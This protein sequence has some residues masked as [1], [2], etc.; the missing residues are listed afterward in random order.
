MVE[1]LSK[2]G[3]SVLPDPCNDRRVKNLEAPPNK[4]L[5]KSMLFPYAGNTECILKIYHRH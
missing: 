2:L 4:P 1:T 3:Y 5:A